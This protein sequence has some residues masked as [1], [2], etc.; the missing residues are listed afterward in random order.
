[1]SE[2]DKRTVLDCISDSVMR[3][4]PDVGKLMTYY[5]LLEKQLRL[6]EERPVTPENVTE[7]LK[8]MVLSR[9]I[10]DMMQFRMQNGD[11]I[12]MTDVVVYPPPPFVVNNVGIVKGKK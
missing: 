12:D 3:N 10:T 6:I 4:I 11:N 1:M 2:E 5:G 7:K 9:F 8:V